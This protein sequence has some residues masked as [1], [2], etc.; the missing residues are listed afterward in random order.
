MGISLSSGIPLTFIALNV[1][2]FLKLIYYKYLGHFLSILL[3]LP[4]DFLFHFLL[5]FFE[6]VTRTRHFVLQRRSKRPY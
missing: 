4:V 1:Q 3:L 5:S 2:N 6:Y